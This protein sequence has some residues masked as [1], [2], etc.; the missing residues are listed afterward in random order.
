MKVVALIPAR[1]GSKGV[2]NKNLQKIAGLP[3]ISISINLAKTSTHIE[4]IF[5]SSDSEEILKIS[6]DSG[7]IPLRRPKEI[8]GDSST[9]ND[10]VHHFLNSD[11]KFENQDLI[12]VYLQ[13]TS[14]FTSP[15][16][17]SRCIELYLE[18]HVPIVSMKNISEHPNKMLT[19]DN[20]GRVSNYILESD[21]TLN[22]QELQE[23]LIPTGGIYIFSSKDFIEN[24]NIP[25]INSLPYIVHGVEGLDIDNEFDLFLA[26]TIGA[27]NEL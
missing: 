8:S 27:S 23:L 5:V 4:S 11:P 10:V 1:A 22:R 13:P 7:A 12:I 18:K 16:T 17:L 24:G 21:P 9:A 2:K 19:Q 3:L 25:V 14:P 6:G 15:S 26:Q 20:F